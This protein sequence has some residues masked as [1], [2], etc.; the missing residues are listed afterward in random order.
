LTQQATPSASLPAIQASASSV[1]RS[2]SAPK[3]RSAITGL[4]GLLFRSST[5]AKFQLKPS[6]LTARATAAPTVARQVGIVGRAQ[7]HRRRRRRHPGRAHHGAAFLVERDQR[8]G[9]IAARR[10]AVSLPSCSESGHILAE[11]ADAANTVLADEVGGARI[12]RRCR[13]SGS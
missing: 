6:A 10:S 1:A 5:G 7:R 12:Q 4:C 11:Q 8:V 2:G 9:P 3:E 13:T